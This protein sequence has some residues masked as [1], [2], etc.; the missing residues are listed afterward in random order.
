VIRTLE[1]S[2]GRTNQSFERSHS[3]IRQAHCLI[4]ATHLLKGRNRAD[5][6]GSSYPHG[7]RGAVA[8]QPPPA[9][10]ARIVD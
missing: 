5:N 9:Y 2:M 7:A 10:E 8:E 6:R 3:A 1:P 4:A